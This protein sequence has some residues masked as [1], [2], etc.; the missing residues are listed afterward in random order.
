[1]KKLFLFIVF[2]FLFVTEN[3][4]AQQNGKIELPGIPGSLSWINNPVK[5]Q[6]TETGII[7]EAGAKTDKYI[8][9]DGSYII[10]NAPHFV[11]EADSNFIFSARIKHSFTNQW[12]AGALVLICDNVNYVKYCFEKDYKGKRR[13]VSVVT[14]NTS[15]DCN[16][17]ETDSDM[18]FYQIAKQGK[19]VFLYCSN[20]GKDWYLVRS[21]EIKEAGKTKVGFLAQ[22]PSG[23][24][25]T[26]EFSDIK[27]KT[28]LM[29][30]F[31]KGE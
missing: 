7:I 12:D 11:F 28:G 16:S 1:M 29:K 17:M 22:S 4:P 15:D 8:A 13:V 3:L 31:W 18:I 30:D 21:V 23:E 20:D 5:Y 2:A 10:D 6:I 26:V 24:S 19:V 25:N 14:K 27:Y 9:A